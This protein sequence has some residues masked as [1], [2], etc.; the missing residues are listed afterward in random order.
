MD[1][2]QRA[3][4]A[5]GNTVTGIYDEVAAMGKLGDWG[6]AY[7]AFR[8]AGS[9]TSYSGDISL[10]HVG[11]CKDIEAYKPSGAF[12]VVKQKMHRAE[13]RL[14]IEAAPHTVIALA[15]AVPSGAP[16]GAPSQGAFFSR[17][18]RLRNFQGR[19]ATV[20][21]GVQKSVSKGIKKMTSGEELEQ[22]ANDAYNTYVDIAKHDR[23]LRTQLREAKKTGDKATQEE[24]QARVN[25]S[26]SQVD[27]AKAEAKRLAEEAHTKAGLAVGIRRYA[28]GGKRKTRKQCGNS[29]KKT[30][31]Q[32]KH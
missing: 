21:T 17:N 16:R 2:V 26:I 12:N 20:L 15:K 14:A 30:R 27:L 6:V 18:G 10:K 24:L 32:R 8:A 28:H 7:G 29:G 22:A 11:L 25:V 23:N 5:A 3:L 9:P 31:K 13:G 4:G 1:T 19:F